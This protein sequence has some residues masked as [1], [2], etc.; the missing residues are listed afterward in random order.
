[1][2]LL[3]KKLDIPENSILNFRRYQYNLIPYFIKHCFEYLRG[4]GLEYTDDEIRFE[5][6][7]PEYYQ[8]VKNTE[9][10]I[11]TV[12]IKEQK[13]L[14]IAIPILIEDTFF[15]IN[16]HLYIPIHYI[17]DG[18]ITLKKKS[19]IIYSLFKPITIYYE[20]KE[21][22]IIFNRQ[23]FA[24]STFLRLFFTE[25]EVRGLCSKLEIGFIEE[26][27]DDVLEKFSKMLGFSTIQEQSMLIDY[28]ER[29]F[30]DSHTKNYFE[31]FYN[32]N[33]ITLKGILQNTLMRIIILELV[34]DINVELLKI[35]SDLD[36]IDNIKELSLKLLNDK[37]TKKYFETF[38]KFNIDDINTKSDIQDVITRIMSD[39]KPS[40]IDLKSKRIIFTEA[41]LQPIFES[42]GMAVKKLLQ[43]HVIQ[44]IY[45]KPGKMTI[46]KYFQL[47]LHSKNSYDIHNSYA[48]LLVN[49][50]SFNK[51]AKEKSA[52]T[53]KSG[54]P[55]E[56]SGI[57]ETYFER[58]CP[59][60][61]S[62]TSIGESI[63]LVPDLVL[64]DMKY[65]IFDI[66]AEE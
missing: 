20:K 42:V 46:K 24:I 11:L 16:G 17:V 8:H 29:L 25:K 5:Y 3:K 51:K 31:V 12:Y 54:L 9:Y 18:P 49:K 28:V 36:E 35:T 21:N 41:L 64:K 45:L 48:G 26:S 22:R 34:N 10:T 37:Y 47:H 1:M 39:V 13:F 15:M 7:K 4:F 44:K 38:Y 61:I 65:G 40:F 59:I 53:Y 63:Q 50:A 19:A 33:N 23:N 62:N 27:N 66:P 30:L 57:H 58:V 56:I 55:S 60:S 32:T 52:K 2:N 14:E 6:D 43:E